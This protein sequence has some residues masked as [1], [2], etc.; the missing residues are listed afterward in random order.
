[1]D[2]EALWIKK[3]KRTGNESAANALVSKYYKEIYAYLYKQTLDNDL[4]LDL[5]QEVFISALKS[6]K[7]RFELGCIK[8]LLTGLSIITDRKVIG[9][10]K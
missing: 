9:M 3:I 7:R 6:I 1:M 2:N 8:L 5:T 4:S 10:H